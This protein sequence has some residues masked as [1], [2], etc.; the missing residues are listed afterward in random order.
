MKFKLFVIFFTVL[1]CCSS[2]LACQMYS[3]ASAKRGDSFIILNTSTGKIKSKPLDENG[4][5]AEINLSRNP[6][7][8]RNS[9]DQYNRSTEAG[10]GHQESCGRYSMAVLDG[11]VVVVDTRDGTHRVLAI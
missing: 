6:S 5:Y 4:H 3:V 8:R 10:D 11:A 1:F 9:I 7:S 2:A